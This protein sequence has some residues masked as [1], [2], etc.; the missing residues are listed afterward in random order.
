MTSE[1]YHR[2]VL[3]NSIWEHHRPFLPVYLHRFGLPSTP[4]GGGSLRVT[5]MWSLNM[6]PP[7]KGP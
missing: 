2:P 7:T 1:Y 5:S 6:P 3:Y 4:K